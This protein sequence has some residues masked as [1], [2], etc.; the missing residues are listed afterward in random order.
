MKI[1]SAEEVE[2]LCYQMRLSDFVRGQNRAL[3]D[4]LFNG[5]PP[6]DDQEVEENQI[7]VNVNYLEGTRIGMD[8]RRQ[9][10]NA[11]LK[12]GQFFKL[13][14]DCGPEHKRSERSMIVTREINRVMKRS[15]P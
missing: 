10:Y 14:T 15:L 2:M 1:T 9:F 11:F 4:D 8:A 13:T 12:P 6:Y 3:I 7:K 5:V